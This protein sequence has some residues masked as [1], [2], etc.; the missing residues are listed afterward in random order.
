MRNFLF[1][2]HNLWLHNFSDENHCSHAKLTRA[3]QL[4]RLIGIKLLSEIFCFLRE[5]SQLK[6]YKINKEH[7]KLKRNRGLKRN[8]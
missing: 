4:I 5:T 1:A 7:Y 3:N 6:I 8:I 2:L